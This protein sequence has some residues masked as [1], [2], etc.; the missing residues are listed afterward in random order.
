[1]KKA[2][3]Y[4]RS[5]KDRAELGIDAQRAELTSFAER[6]GLG[7]VEEFSDMELSG[8]GDEVTRPGLAKLLEA[9]RNRSRGWNILLAVDTSRIS[10]DPMLAI[11]ITR[12]C[13][14]NSVDIRYAKVAIDGSS[15]YGEMMLGVARQFDRLHS[16]LSAE[17]GKQGQIE[18]VK[19]GYRSGGR[20]PLGYR[21]EKISTGGVRAGQ[22]VMKSR[23]VPDPLL[24]P[25]IAKFLTLRSEG[26]NRAESMRRS[27][28]VDRNAA[29]MI[30]VESNAMIYTGHL[31]WNRRKKLRANRED[32]RQ[33]MLMRDKEEWVVSEDQTHEA[34]ISL[35][36]AEAVL[37]VTTAKQKQVR[38]LKNDHDFL[39]TGLLYTPD[40]IPF[41]CETASG[42]YRA[43]AKGKRISRW[44]IEEEVIKK[45]HCDSQSSEFRK[46]LVSAA[47]A[48]GAS[49]K[50]NIPAINSDIAALKCQLDNLIGLVS[51]GSKA[52]AAK[53]ASIESDLERLEQLKA[54]QAANTIIKKKLDDLSEGDIAQMLMSLDVMNWRIG[55]PGDD[56]TLMDIP[57]FVSE[58]EKQNAEA[59]LRLRRWITTLLD[60]VVFDPTTRLVEL[61]YKWA[62]GVLLASPRGFEPRYS[63]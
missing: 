25:K 20:P 56:D 30:G 23:L 1:M 46:K 34:L 13:E 12:E 58:N 33:R 44:L 41:W 18:N 38:R 26:V 28:L 37:A 60:R 5:S 6:D 16:R 19:Q 4:L 52:A 50:V 48:F 21:L 49:I 59:R 11:Y 61:H 9:I 47:K 14:K 22:P 55:K 8:S 42:N 29:T 32:P 2:A 57:E 24:A 62:G 39:L 51:S 31:I 27:E 3:T 17:K 15:A 63:P 45:L 40:D 53:V 10:R 35:E 54:D 43:G 7:L 36:Q